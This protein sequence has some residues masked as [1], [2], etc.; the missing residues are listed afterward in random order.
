MTTTSA[1]EDKTVYILGTGFSIPAGAPPHARILADIFALDTGI[2]RDK[3]AKDRLQEFLSDLRILPK[4]VATVALEDI[5]T[6]IDRYLATKASKRAALAK[7]VGHSSRAKQYDPF[8]I[9]S[10]N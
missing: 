8:S 9:I 10:L 7:D 4:D 5:Y 2:E 6:P 3:K 1:Q